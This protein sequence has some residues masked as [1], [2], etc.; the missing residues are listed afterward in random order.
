[1]RARVG[2]RGTLGA[3]GVDDEDCAEHQTSSDP[4]SAKT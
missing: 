2:W 3:R 1:V 4:T